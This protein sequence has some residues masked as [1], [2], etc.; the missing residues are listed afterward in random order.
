[1]SG[2]DI[3][4]L[5]TRQTIRFNGNVRAA[6]LATLPN[7]RPGTSLLTAGWGINSHTRQKGVWKAVR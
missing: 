1:M 5:K 7:V 4:L 6:R 2:N 3:A